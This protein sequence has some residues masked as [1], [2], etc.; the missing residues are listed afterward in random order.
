MLQMMTQMTWMM[1]LKD[2]SR[3]TLKDLEKCSNYW[4]RVTSQSRAGPAT[5]LLHRFWQYVILPGPARVGYA[6]LKGTVLLEMTRDK[7]F[8]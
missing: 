3:M 5:P 8:I 6:K 4:G 1:I 2:L 7:T